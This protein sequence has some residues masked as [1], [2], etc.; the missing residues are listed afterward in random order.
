[1]KHSYLNILIK[2]YAEKFTLAYII[3]FK[4]SFNA[5][6]LYPYDATMIV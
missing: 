6:T 3:N 5:E 1:M 4:P 2:Y